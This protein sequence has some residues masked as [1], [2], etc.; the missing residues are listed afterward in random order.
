MSALPDLS[1]ARSHYL[2]TVPARPAPIGVYANMAQKMLIETIHD[3]ETRVAVVKD[4]SLEKFDFESPERKAHKGNIYLAKIKRVEPALQA[5]FVDYGA[6]KHGFLPFSEIHSSYYRIP[7][8][9]RPPG[10]DDDDDDGQVD[11]TTDDMADGDA[12]G[13]DKTDDKTNDNTSGREQPRRGRREK[14]GRDERSRYRIQDVIRNDQ[15]VLVQLSKEE[16]GNKGAAFTSKIA[17]PG[18]YCVLVTKSSRNSGI[19]RRIEDFKERKNLKEIF[20]SLDVPKGMSVI[21]RTAGRE[22]SKAEVKRDFESL[23]R[24]WEEIRKTTLRSEAPKTIYEDGALIQRAVRD[25]YHR[26]IDEILVD[27]DSGY[28]EARAALR[29]FIPS[30]V[31]RVKRYQSD[32]PLFEK[33]DIESQIDATFSPVCPLKSGGYLVINVTEAVITIDVNSGRSTRQRNIEDTALEINLEAAHE[34]ARQLCLRNLAGLIVIDFIDMEKS[35]NNAKVEKV[36]NEALKDDRSRIQTSRISRFGLLEMSRQRMGPSL[37]DRSTSLCRSCEGMGRERLPGSSSLQVLRAVSHHAM[38]SPEKRLNVWTRMPIVMSL[39]NEKRQFLHDLE[40][41]HRVEIHIRAF[42]G[43]SLEGEDLYRV[44]VAALDGVGDD[45]E[46]SPSPSRGRGRPAG[47]TARN[48]RESPPDDTSDTRDASPKAD[49]GKAVEGDDKDRSGS[50]DDT[51]RERG[52]KKRQRGRGGQSRRTSSITARNRG[53]GRESPEKDTN[54]KD[55]NE[56]SPGRSP[57]KSREKSRGRS[58][59]RK[60]GSDDDAINAE[61]AV[62][63]SKDTSKPKTP[64]RKTSRRQDADTDVMKEGA[65]AEKKAREKKS[66][67]KSKADSKDTRGTK[68][69]RTDA[70][71][72]SP[73]KGEKDPKG[74]ARRPGRRAKK[75]DEAVKKSDL[76]TPSADTASPASDA[77]KRRDFW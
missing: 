15:I 38:K 75:G 72:E 12:D 57:E 35:G 33:F 24:R 52:D 71:K 43:E 29:Q 70:V 10:L 21:I 6:E 73:E 22:R 19:S 77:L 31:R 27:S 13:E 20:A 61:K 58:T 41:K 17:L 23:L 56:K 3:G 76:T 16:R 67:E 2:Y 11:D 14:R 37:I 59:R 64:R 44:D 55:T 49:T 5:A 65:G 50:D 51:T 7:V 30:H 4:G 36:L 66:E 62:R 1:V 68:R 63:D 26:D 47:R 34:A 53:A 74:R 42:P 40:Q 54:E 46:K 39:L 45:D 48:R 69:K 8:G 9:D 60:F 32:M 25:I 28:K 18:R